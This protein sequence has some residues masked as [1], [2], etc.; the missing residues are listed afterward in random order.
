MRQK[1]GRFVQLPAQYFNVKNPSGF[2]GTRERYRVAQ[3]TARKNLNYRVTDEQIR[4]YQ[5]NL[6]E[7]TPEQQ[8]SLF[9]MYRDCEERIKML[10]S[11]RFAT[12]VLRLRS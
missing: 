9:G 3:I 10:N 11:H 8:E 12:K 1:E 5:S 7:R 4:R 6:Q 2:V